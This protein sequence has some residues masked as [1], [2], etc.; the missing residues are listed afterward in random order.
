V[1]PLRDEYSVGDVI[2]C[3]ANGWPAPSI[4]WRW[5]NGPAAD[6]AVD[7][8]SLTVTE[9]MKEDRNEWKCI[10]TNNI[11]EDEWTIMFNVSGELKLTWK[12]MESHEV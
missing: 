10:A 5:I 7:G 2:N 11:G 12:D 8:R 4:T 9:E 1:E 3:S 6:G